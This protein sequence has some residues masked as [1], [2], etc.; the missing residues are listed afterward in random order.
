MLD[1]ILFFTLLIAEGFTLR[2]AIGRGGLIPFPI[3]TMVYLIGAQIILLLHAKGVL[4]YDFLRIYTSY[5]FIYHLRST[6]LMF[7]AIFF[8]LTLCIPK[9][10]I[11]IADQIGTIVVR[12]VVLWSI[13]FAVAAADIYL[14]TQFDWD[15]LWSNRAYLTMAGDSVLRE[16]QVFS[17]LLVQVHPLLGVAVIAAC[18]YAY[19][20]RRFAVLATGILFALWHLLFA[21]A[22]HSR[23]VVAY[24]LIASLLTA[25]LSRRYRFATLLAV[26][27]ILAQISVL[28]G[29]N[30]GHH[31]F[32]SLSEFVPNMLAYLDHT[33][34]GAISNFFEGTFSTSEYFARTFNYA[35]IY[36]VL[37][38]SPMVS[39]VD[40]FG[41]IREAY[42]LRLHQ[43]VPVSA[44]TEVLS[45]GV[46]Y[47]AIFFAVELLAGKLSADLMSKRPGIVP[48]MLNATVFLGSYLQFAYT[49]RSV[50][51]IFFFTALICLVLSRFGVTRVDRGAEPEARRTPRRYAP[52]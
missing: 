48:L 29:R 15:V 41:T 17:R 18:V 23:Y 3:G 45:F 22:S 5:A 33:P 21:I 13:V 14:F 11:S 20:T 40:G 35:T 36:K 12:D 46:G 2:W 43:Y 25:I 31:G 27:G 24:L 34:T 10:R 26:L 28:E 8:A 1:Y 47:A 32:S 19:N 4:E 42:E 30:S 7:A 9:T 39:A 37:S 49:T 52:R 16:P 50:F 6:L 44:V 51:R 38:L